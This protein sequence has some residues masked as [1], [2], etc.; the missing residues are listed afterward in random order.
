MLYLFFASIF[1]R[2]Q[3]D[4]FKKGL[5]V[6]MLRNPLLLWEGQTFLEAIES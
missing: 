2:F 5:G 3:K 1:Q 4:V 6:L